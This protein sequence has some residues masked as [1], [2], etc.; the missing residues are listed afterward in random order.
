LILVDGNQKWSNFLNFLR[1]RSIQTPVVSA[2]LKDK[3]QV[4][5]FTGLQVL[6]VVPKSKLLERLPIILREY[7][8]AKYKVTLA[9]SESDRRYCRIPTGM[10]M[11]IARFGQISIFAYLR[12]NCE[13][14]SQGR[15]V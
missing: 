12:K 10:L 11:R 7:F 9:E 8:I 15:R 1:E 5:D 2:V 4:N 6:E 3:P 13:T 14:L